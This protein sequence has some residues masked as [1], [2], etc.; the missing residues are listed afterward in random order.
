MWKP[1]GDSSSSPTTL[2]CPHLLARIYKSRWQVELLFKWIKQHLRIKSF[3]STSE[4]AVQTQIRIA[5][6]VYVLVALN[7]GDGRI[8]AGRAH[9]L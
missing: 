7:F 4:N 8:P 6:S 5:V 3:Y 9:C 1:D 2:H